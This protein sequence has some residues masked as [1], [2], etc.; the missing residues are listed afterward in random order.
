MVSNCAYSISDDWYL[1]LREAV[2][3][4]VVALKPHN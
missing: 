4:Y 2:L 3:A 1:A